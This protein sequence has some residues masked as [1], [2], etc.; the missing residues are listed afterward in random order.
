MA[1]ILIFAVAII[2]LLWMMQIVFFEEF[3]QRFTS[4]Q[5]TRSASRMVK[6]IDD[7][8]E[9]GQYVQDLSVNENYCIQ[10]YEKLDD[11]G[12][13]QT[14][15]VHESANATCGAYALTSK[16]EINTLYN[17]V[18]ENKNEL[19]EVKDVQL[20]LAGQ[21]IDTFTNMMVS[22]VIESK[23]GNT[24]MVVVNARL[25][26]TAETVETSKRQLLLITG[27]VLGMSVIIAYLTA[28]TIA[29]PIQQTNEKAKQLAQND[30]DIHFDAE[31][32][33]EIEE[34]NETLNYAVQELK[35]VESMRNE[36]MANVSHDLRTPLT[37]ITGYGEVMRDL[38]GE[39][40]KEN[41]QVIIDE[42]QRLTQL[43]NNL[44]DLSKLQNNTQELHIKEFD[45]TTSIQDIVNRINKMLANDGYT[46]EFNYGHEIFVYA[47]KERINQVVYNIVGNA[48]HFTGSDKKVFVNQID[49]GHRVRIEITDT[50]KGIKKSQ[51]PYIWDRY[52]KQPKKWKRQDIG[53]GLGLNIVKGILELHRVEYGVESEINKGTTFYFYLDKA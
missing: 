1:F 3:Y 48:I 18:I 53:T 12:N 29:K 50:G 17:Q 9:F 41:I 40:T 31:G 47:D 4:Q 45:V 16:M 26:P 20:E 22:N 27:I 6:R 15:D 35:K 37:M 33:S 7:V 42:A 13:F 25:S 51:I 46:I 24:Y 49:E 5:I 39:N 8:D 34:L 14:V 2:A 32:Y 11:V 19:V 38:P 28:K 10:V 21:R 23:K 52:F 36:L 30:L 43:V 44:L